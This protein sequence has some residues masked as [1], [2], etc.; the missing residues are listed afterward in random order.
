MTSLNEGALGP[1]AEPFL[2]ADDFDGDEDNWYIEQRAIEIG[3]GPHEAVI[4]LR[5]AFKRRARLLS[6]VSDQPET[7]APAIP[8]HGSALP[9]PPGRAGTIARFLY[10]TSYC[11]IPEV[12]ITATV[13]LLA[14]VC[15]RAYRTYSGIDLALYMILV[16]KSGVGKD[17]MH[18]GIPM[19]LELADR[20]M[21]RGFVRAQDFASGEALHK[22]LLREPGFLYLQGEFGKK[23]KRM[24]NPLDAPMQ[25]FRTIMTKAFGKRFLEGKSYS[26]PEDSLNGVDWPALS[27]VGETTP[28]TFLE[29]ITPDMM[30]D[31]FLSRFLVVNYGGDRPPTNRNRAA[32]FPAIDR[33]LWCALVD[34]VIRYQFPVNTPEA[35]TVIADPESAAM[36]ERF[37]EE[38]RARLNGT[39]DETQ[40][41][42]WN[43]AHLKVLKVASLLAVADHY[44]A[45]V[46]TP[47][48]VRWAM[49]LVE[50]DVET[51]QTR[52]R[53]GDIGVDDDARQRKLLSFLRDY[54]VNPVP[55][56]YG[57]KAKMV[58]N[59]IVPR[60]YLQMRSAS[61]SAFT[62]HK[63]GSTR[64]LDDAIRSLIANGN[65]MEVK[66]DRL[67]E[68]YG[69]GGVS[70]RILEL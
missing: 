39:D 3:A 65:L 4:E 49:N 19:M 60:K 24:A 29:C 69:F 20:P 43:R 6:P 47:E 53:D 17:G 54:I 70:Y 37:D 28:G 41:Q 64:A 16:A 45:P 30:A 66:R 18:D 42:V 32:T 67:M 31:G 57:I 63:L 38:C 21:A 23:L 1:Q 9:W 61:L 26:N 15:G 52:Q 10:Q 34:H 62:N 40:R 48:H 14:G 68:G 25:S 59:S 50:Q 36:F 12:S 33:E 56:S 35:V 7:V 8:D 13:A 44:L 11:P 5:A 58:E 55:S 51:F 27:F 22:E 2:R 46:V